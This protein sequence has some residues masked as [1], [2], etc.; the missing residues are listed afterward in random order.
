M[1]FNS[2]QFLLVYL[3][4]CYAGFLLVHRG[5]GW[6]GVYAYLS[7][8]SVVFYAFFSLTLACILIGS[9]AAN[10][11]FARAIVSAERQSIRNWI[12]GFAITANLAALGY[13]KYANF[14]IDIANDVGVAGGGHLDLIAP[15]GISFYTFTQIGYLLEAAARRTEQI[16]L[17]RYALF[18]GF[19][20]CV[21]AGPLLMQ[22]DFLS[23]TLGR[24]DRAFTPTRV[25]IGLTMFGIGLAKKVIIADSIAPHADVVFD[26]VAAGGAVAMTEAWIGSLSYTLQLYFDFSGYSD[27]A[28]GIAFLF[29]FKLPLNFNSPFKAVSISDFWNRWHMTMTRFFTNFLYTH[30]AMRNSRRAVQ[31]GYGRLHKWMIA[32]AAPIFYTFVVAGVW[33]GAGWTFVVYGVIHGLALAV[34]HGW[35]EWSLPAP[36][37]LIGWAMTMFVVVTGLT[38][39]RAPD[40]AV[41]TEMLL[42]MWGVS[43]VESAY[44]RVD[45]GTAVAMIAVGAAIVLT[46]PNSQEILRSHWISSDAEPTKVSPSARVIRWAPNIGWAIAVA[47]LIVLSTASIEDGVGFLYYDF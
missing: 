6:R 24:T 13:F 35:R 1:T 30:M 42:A 16:S 44:V 47:T 7:L 31:K 32:G 11:F 45:I 41:A 38:V 27:M 10:F 2:L 43:S 40:L 25:A 33:H 12:A 18:A 17:S 37:P 26:G 39:F 8:A 29:G 3:P 5:L 9:I 36:P 46:L 34:N 20:P 4:I 23:Q 21:T 15:I 19:F 22:R 14:F 28:I